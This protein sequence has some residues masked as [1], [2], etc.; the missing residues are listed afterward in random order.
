ME[1]LIVHTGDSEKTKI[2]IAFLKALHIKFEAKRDI[3]YDSKFVKKIQESANE[4]ANG[5]VTAIET[6]DLWK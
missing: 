1:T 6:A 2:V 4:A 3:P 5:N